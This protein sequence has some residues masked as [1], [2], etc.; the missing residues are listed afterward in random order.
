MKEFPLSLAGY[1]LRQRIKAL[2]GVLAIY[3]SFCNLAGR[4]QLATVFSK[5]CMEG[6]PR[7]GN[8]FSY[9]CVVTLLG[10]PPQVIAHHTHSPANVS[11]AVRRKL[12]TYVFVRE[13]M[14]ACVSL[15]LYGAC[16][17]LEESLQFYEDFYRPLMP[18]L[19]R[20]VV[21][22]F[23]DL[24]KSPAAFLNRVADDLKLDRVDWSAATAALMED[25]VRR[26]DEQY[27]VENYDRNSLPSDEKDRRKAQIAS[28]ELSP[29]TRA[30]LERCTALRDTMLETAAQVVPPR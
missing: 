23:E 9:R 18:L 14:D 10:V 8:S 6:F 20:I 2:P 24:V 26:A 15:I 4:S 3:L 25:V 7:S 29:Q 19:D 17:T 12:P 5:M 16:K 11:R 21:I 1:A 28:R 22:P 27:Q 13:P 30:R